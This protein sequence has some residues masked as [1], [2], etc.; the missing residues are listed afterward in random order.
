[1]KIDEPLI[2]SI[3][4]AIPPTSGTKRLNT[5]NNSFYE[6]QDEGSSYLPGKAL[7]SDEEED[8][9]LYYNQNASLKN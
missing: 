9:F 6:S 2:P 4:T 1:M 3:S 7:H 5:T 8:I